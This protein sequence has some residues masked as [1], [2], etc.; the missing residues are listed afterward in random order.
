MMMAS[1]LKWIVKVCLPIALDWAVKSI[2]S[3]I[4]KSAGAMKTVVNKKAKEDDEKIDKAFSSR[5]ESALRG[6]RDDRPDETKD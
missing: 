3:A 6:L 5:D 2:E 1:A 4:K